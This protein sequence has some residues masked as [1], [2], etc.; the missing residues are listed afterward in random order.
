MY[1]TVFLPS[2]FFTVTHY[3][4]NHHHHHQLHNFHILLQNALCFVT[5]Y[6][7]GKILFSLLNFISLIIFKDRT[8]FVKCPT[9]AACK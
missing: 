4:Y 1:I 6:V 2:L 3:Y 5:A 7:N 8:F 9:G